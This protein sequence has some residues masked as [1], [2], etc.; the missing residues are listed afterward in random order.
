LSL[1]SVEI[2][3]TYLMQPVDKVLKPLF[4]VSQNNPSF[5]S[6]HLTKVK[7]SIGFAIPI[8]DLFKGP[9]LWR[10]LIYTALM[11]IGKVVCGLWLVRVDIQ[12]LRNMGN[13]IRLICNGVWSVAK[14]GAW[15]GDT[16]DSKNSKTT[17]D[18]NVQDELTMKGND[19][20]ETGEKTQEDH[21]GKGQTK[22]VG[23]TQRQKRL[24]TP[25]KNPISLYPSAILGWAM[26]ARGEIGFLI[27]SI[28]E[29]KG[30]WRD[31][32]SINDQQ[33]RATS[34]N[35]FIVVNWAIFLCT[36][37]GPIMVGLVVRRLRRL[38]KGNG[39]S[40]RF[41]ALGNWGVG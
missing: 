15:K 3:E 23:G 26:V 20:S 9:L 18:H 34:S 33:S 25:T 39:Y 19:P 6:T 36:F 17:G 27:A 21:T 22:M 32:S 37:I 31:D 1:S 2:Y 5:S 10:G 12:I 35:T 24:T 38:E 11:I 4:F 40:G 14:N 30:I 41:D 7:A 29:S 16:K 8:S 13:W 28:A